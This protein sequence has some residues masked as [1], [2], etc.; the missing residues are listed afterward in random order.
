MNNSASS[1]L[2]IQVHALLSIL[3][4]Y[5]PKILSWAALSPGTCVTWST[6]GRAW[7]PHILR[8]LTFI[9]SWPGLWLMITKEI[10]TKTRLALVFIGNY[11]RVVDPILFPSPPEVD[12]RTA[13]RHGFRPCQSAAGLEM[14]G[15]KFGL[16]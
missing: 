13:Y 12:W 7:L 5:F 14:N 6:F 9:F 3:L 16:V 8:H 11:R 15:A 4:Q 10:T 2:W 1:I